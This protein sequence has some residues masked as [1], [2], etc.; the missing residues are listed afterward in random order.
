MGRYWPIPFVG[1]K[2]TAQEEGSFVWKLRPELKEAIEEY[3]LTN[4]LQDLKTNPVKKKEVITM[5]PKNT[6]LYGP[7]GTGKTYNSA[8]YAVAI[9]EGKSVEEVRAELY[10]DIMNRYNEYKEQGQIEFATFHQSYG[11]EEFIEGIRPMMD[12][13]SEDDGNIEYQITSGLFKTFCERASRPVI[14]KNEDIGL[15]SNPTIWKVSLERTGDN[16]TRTECMKNN[17]IRIGYDSYGENITDETELTDGK[18]VL[19]AFISRM[20]IGDIVFS[21]YSATTIDAIGVVTGDYE[22]HDEYKQYKRL[23]KVNWLV[24]GIKEGILREKP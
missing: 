22:W 12:E 24:K 16:S 23:R 4:Y 17:H 18:T 5:I 10:S 3:G 1:R 15:N 13:N 7:P 14:I 6:I 2:A 8:I 11:Y 20:K 21:C 9:I 19:N